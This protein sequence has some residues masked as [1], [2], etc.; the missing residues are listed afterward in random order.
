MVTT[1]SNERPALMPWKDPLQATVP[2]IR[3]GSLSAVYYGQRR[4]G[5]FYDFVSAAPDRVLFGLFDV[6]G[7]PQQTRGIMFDL[8]RKFRSIGAKLLK[9]ERANEPNS[10]LK[11]W[12]EI[13]R[14]ILTSAGGVHACSAVFG[15]YDDVAGTVWY[16]NAGH[17]AGLVRHKQQVRELEATALPFGL[18]ARPVAPDASLVALNP[19]DALLLV[20][21]G[22][23]EANYRGEEYGLQRVGEYLDHSRAESAHEV[24]VGLLDR[25]RQFM[26]TAPTH[27]DVTALA[28]VR[29]A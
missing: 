16:V 29:S 21:K 3:N 4:S 15:C 25:V 28:L 6:A 22:V 5:D 8:Q 17:I 20:S 10:L 1:A 18:F 14:A 7:E 24:C 13:N 11:L 27:D 9:A 23:V 19:G 12:I 2:A 26:H